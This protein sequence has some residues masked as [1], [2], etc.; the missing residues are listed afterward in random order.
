MT[1][2]NDDVHVLLENHRLFLRF[3]EKKLVDRVLARDILQEAFARA[4][5]PE[6]LPGVEGVAFW[7]YR[8]V[9]NA[10]V[11]ALMKEPARNHV[12]ELF[13]REIENRDS[14]AGRELRQ[15]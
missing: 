14:T 7:F 9:R 12:L 6:F 13:A 2:E 10:V 5:E 3:L 15:E 11:H 4:L 8:S 1:D